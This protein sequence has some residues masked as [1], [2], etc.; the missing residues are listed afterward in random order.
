MNNVLKQLPSLQ[1]RAPT[2]WTDYTRA[3]GWVC[4]C[5][6]VFDIVLGFKNI[7]IYRL[8]PFTHFISQINQQIDQFVGQHMPDP[9]QSEK[10]NWLINE[11]TAEAHELQ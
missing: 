7:F 11:L 2:D 8:L 5:T 9:L 6:P 1:H 3:Y 10:H 4:V